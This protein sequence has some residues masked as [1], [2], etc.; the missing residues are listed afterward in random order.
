MQMHPAHM[1]YVREYEEFCLQRT[2]S[3]KL[4]LRHVS[5]WLREKKAQLQYLPPH[6][7]KFELTV[8]R[9]SIRAWRKFLQKG[10][11]TETAG[12]PKKPAKRASKK[13]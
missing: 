11:T 12:S 8:R 3:E 6:R 4:D 5:A 7:T 9:E 13:S 2:G 10:S 1:K